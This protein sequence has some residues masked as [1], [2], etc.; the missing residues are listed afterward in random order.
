MIGVPFFFF[1]GGGNGCS[2]GVLGVKDTR[3]GGE[4]YHESTKVICLT[5]H[6]KACNGLICTCAI[7]FHN[8][9]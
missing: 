8:L 6:P 3:Q 7:H 4:S 1:F 2:T 9:S 5:A